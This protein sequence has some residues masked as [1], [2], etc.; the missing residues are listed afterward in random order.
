MCPAGIRLPTKFAA[1]GFPQYDTS[2]SPVLI[3]VEPDPQRRHFGEHLPGQR[4]RARRSWE[5]L[6]RRPVIRR[7]HPELG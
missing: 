6:R 4:K 3:F 1:I 7:R 5:R 2:I